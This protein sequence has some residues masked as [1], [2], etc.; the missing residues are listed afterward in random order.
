[1]TAG[2]AM[3]RTPESERVRLRTYRQRSRQI[4][5]QLALVV[6]VTIVIVLLALIQR[7]AQARRFERR[8]LDRIAQV[9]QEARG[10]QAAAVDL[11][12]ILRLDDPLWQRYYFNESYSRQAWGGREIGVG[13]SRSAVGLLLGNDGRFVIL[14]DG[15]QYR[16]EWLSEVQFRRNAKGLGLE[17][18]LEE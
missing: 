3:E 14:Y 11:F 8:E 16:V 10:K 12:T 13:C 4:W 6:V 5:R 17:L 9:L 1:M 18:A 7:D 15:G 2:R